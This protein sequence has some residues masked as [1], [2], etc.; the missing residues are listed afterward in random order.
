MKKTLLILLS[1]AMFLLPTTI[2]AVDLYDWQTNIIEKVKPVF[3][4]VDKRIDNKDFSKDSRAWM[5]VQL[6]GLSS[7]LIEQKKRKQESNRS[8]N[9]VFSYLPEAKAEYMEKYDRDGHLLWTFI[10]P[11][12][13]LWVYLNQDKDLSPIEQEE[14]KYRI[15][16]LKRDIADVLSTNTEQADAIYQ[17]IR[18]DYK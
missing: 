9:A 16:E 2:K 17:M 13:L 18:H 1:L 7:E 10:T 8:S 11:T 3:E 14:L 5:S 15:I 12:S 6:Y 4:E